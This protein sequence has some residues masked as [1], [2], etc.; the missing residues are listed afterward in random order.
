MEEIY[1]KKWLKAFTEV[2]QSGGDIREWQTKWETENP[3]P[4]NDNPTITIPKLEDGQ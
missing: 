4:K 1:R 2:I 3:P